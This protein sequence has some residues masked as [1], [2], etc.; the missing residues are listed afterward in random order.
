[1]PS[2]GPGLVC[3]LVFADAQSLDISGPLEVFALASRQAQEEAPGSPP[4]YEV[5]LIARDCDAVKLASGICLLPDL[6]CAQMPGEVDTLLISGG[7]GDAL[8][9]VRA[10]ATLVNWLH[11]A[12]ARARRIGSICNGALLLAEAGLLDHCEAT[13]HWSDIAELQRRYPQVRVVPDAIYTHTGRV[14]TSA[15]ITAGMDLALAMVAADHGAPLALKVARRMV[16]AARRSGGD[17][18]RSRQLDE[19]ELP[20]RFAEF[21][22]WIRENLHA[23]LDVGSLAG[24]MHMSPR[25]FTRRFRAAFGTTPQ[26][27]VAQLRI[28]AAKAQLEHTAKDLKRIAVDCGFSTE[29]AMRRSF[30]R[31]LGVRPGE[32]RQR[33][34]QP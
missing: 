14:W 9:R 8:D 5:R 16:L 13:T 7:M 22:R 32:Y 21:A 26:K 23:R 28:E 6:T 34:A 11:D 29:E 19:L 24:R 18:Q 3:M 30:V 31:Q 25:Q 33:F 12:A 10:D 17:H 1:M 27:Y 15:G 20:D 2:S 4:L